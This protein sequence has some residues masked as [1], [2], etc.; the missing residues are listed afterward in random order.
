MR[1]LTHAEARR[2]SE[3]GLVREAQTLASLRGEPTTNARTLERV[4]ALGVRS[5]AEYVSVS[6]REAF[7]ARLAARHAF[8]ATETMAARPALS[9]QLRDDEEPDND[10]QE[11]RTRAP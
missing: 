6:A 11:T 5:A 4:A 3:R 7:N 2:K 8:F 10:Q 9:A 1:Q